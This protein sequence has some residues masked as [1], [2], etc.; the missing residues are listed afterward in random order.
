MTRALEEELLLVALE[1]AAEGTLRAYFRSS[2]NAD[3]EEEPAPAAS[4]TKAGSPLCVAAVAVVVAVVE[5][6]VV[7]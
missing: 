4:P 2:L 6:V 5:V 3:E 7:E 1:R